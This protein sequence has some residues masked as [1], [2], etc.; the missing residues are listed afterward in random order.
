MASLGRWEFLIIGCGLLLS[1]CGGGGGSGSGGGSSPLRANGDAYSVARGASL[2]VTAPGV[3]GNDVNNAGGTPQA[4]LVSGPSNGTLTLNQDGSFVYQHDG[5]ANSDSFSYRINNGTDSSNEANVTLTLSAVPLAQNGCHSFAA[6]SS[7][8]GQLSATGQSLV[9]EILDQPSKG[10]LSTDVAGNFTYVPNNG[11][12]GLDRFTFRAR[13]SAG[14]TSNIATVSLLIDGAVRLMPLGDSITV[15][16]YTATTPADGSNIG[17]RRKLF[18]DLTANAGNRY[19]VNFVGS[20]QEGQAAQ[21]GDPDH[22]GHGGFTGPQVAANITQW[23]NDQ[24]PDIVLLHIGTNDLGGNPNTDASAIATILQNIASWEQDNYPLQVFVARII[25]RLN[26]PDVT[27][28]ND[29]ME[30]VVASRNNGRLFVVDQ[31]TGA[32]LNY[33]LTGDM[34]DNVHPNQVGYD[35]MATRW[36]SDLNA[37]DVLPTCP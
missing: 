34:A 5:G 4:I 25:Q 1:A 11:R 2:T 32:G 12:R 29:D 27:P 31:Q 7:F 8:T 37:A 10:S 9:Y 18:A 3:L 21:V 20:Q 23:L 16:T 33:A 19:D 24:P 22:E 14:Q 6:N 13:D 26:G 35:K 36:L 17:Y 15:G 30:N 28:Y